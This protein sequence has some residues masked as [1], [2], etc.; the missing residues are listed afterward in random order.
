MIMFANSLVE[1]FLG[2]NFMGQAIV[3]L[4]LL[5]SVIMVAV[6]I[7]KARELSVVSTNTRRFLR[8]FSTGSD[9]LDYYLKRRPSSTTGIEG[10]YKETCERLLKLLTPDVRS[11]LVGRSTDGDGAAALT[12][13]EIELVR[14]TCEH[15]LD[16]EEIRI[17]HGMGV[18]ATVVALSP[19]LGLLGT[20]W[21][22]LDAFAEM[23][24]AGS[25]NLATIAPSISAA[26]VTTV[27]GLLI[28]IPGVIAFNRMNA[29]I[30]SITSDMEGF[31]DELTGRIACE[32]QGR[33][34]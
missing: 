30:R 6:I 18:I 11:L 22:V 17:E 24:T 8:D 33:G 25:A 4:Q 26:L 29:S 23:G 16:E 32:F 21:G 14:S 27:V 31:A 12:A 5:G 20:V 19:M 2:S 3:V 7:G 9:V 13:R 10:I 34:A 1:G 15:S 28:A